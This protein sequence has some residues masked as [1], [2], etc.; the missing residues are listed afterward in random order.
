MNG[1]FEIG[2]VGL[3]SQ[4]Q[5][6]DIIANNIA[7]LNTP[8]FK[9]SDVQFAEI[10]AQRG[11]AANPSTALGAQPYGAG[12]SAH[13]FLAL[14]DQGEIEH[15]G[16]QLDLAIEGQGFVELLGP[17]GEPL[18]WR[19]GRLSVRDDGMLATADGI[20]LR[21]SIN[22]P[23]EARAI[24]IAG[25]GAVR[26]RI[27]ESD[28]I[29]LGRINLVRLE[30]DAGIERRNGGLYRPA[31]TARLIEAPSGEDGMGVLV[32]GA[33]EKSNVDL[34]SEMVRLMIVQRAYAANAQ[35]VQAADQMMA[36]ANGLR[37]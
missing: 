21:A 27:G 22:V 9:R 11:D 35:I 2:G 15:T 19:G 34:N 23:R 14:S 5:A 28:A 24:E 20:A 26:A 18:L 6:L 8:S 3:A 4:S 33:V 36:V 32:Q 12:V 16:V 17:G 31:D 25:D 29:D 30:N 13:S 1:A 37:R 7:N 10:L